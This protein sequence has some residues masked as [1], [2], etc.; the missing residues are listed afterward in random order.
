[1]SLFGLYKSARGCDRTLADEALS[2]NLCRCTGYR[3]IIAAAQRMHALPPAA[4]WRG[5]G[6]D[7]QGRRLVSDEERALAAQLAALRRT[8][9][10][11]MEFAG[12]RYFAPASADELAAL[13]LA[14]PDARLIA[15]ATDVGLWVT[16]QH[17]EL[18]TLIYTGNVRELLA[19]RTT[20]EALE[21][22]AA[23]SLTDAFAL[24]GRHYPTLAEVWSRFGSVPIRN[25]G[26]LGGNLANGSPIGDSMPVLLALGATLILRLGTARRELPLEAF[27]L[28]YQQT[29][30]EPGEFVETVR[31]PLPVPGA[32][33]R[34]YKLS[35]RFD[36]DISAVFVCFHLR[37]DARS[38]DAPIA[39]IRIGCGGMAAIPKRA[40]HCERALSGGHWD[41]NAI[42]NAQVALDRDFAPISDMRASTA[43]R[44]AAL[45]NL[46]RRFYIET[47]QP[48]IATRAIDFVAS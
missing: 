29:A 9:S 40:T 31:I 37:R 11:E 23:V 7:A 38:L 46:L 6:S 22:G 5:P 14:H 3:P 42:M 43:Y 25:S 26:T 32:E 39:E 28:D 19:T 17:R 24:I 33:V 1:M 8:S 48:G 12:Q 45:K 30:R 41:D 10:L 16:K 18:G 21:I 47:T 27:Y 2:G 44:L 13:C 4:G 35:K 20:P 34:A 15:G 36:Q